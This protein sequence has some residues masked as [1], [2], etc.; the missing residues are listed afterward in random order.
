[1]PGE[2]DELAELLHL[3][4]QQLFSGA[5]DPDAPPVGLGERL[6]RHLPAATAAIPAGDFR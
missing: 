3:R 4:G 6:T 2:F 5:V 1:V